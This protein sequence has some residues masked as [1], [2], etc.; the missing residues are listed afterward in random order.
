MAGSSGPQ[1]RLLFD[2][3]SRRGC[4]RLDPAAGVDGDVEPFSRDGECADGKWACRSEVD[5]ACGTSGSRPVV[6]V[7]RATAAAADRPCGRQ[8]AGEG[9]GT[10][11]SVRASPP[12]SS[13][14]QWSNAGT[15]AGIS[16]ASAT[17]PVLN[18]RPVDGCPSSATIK[19][20]K[21]S[22]PR[23][24]RPGHV[25]AVP[26]PVR[27]LG[28]GIDPQG[29]RPVRKRHPRSSTQPQVR[30]VGAP[31]S[32][33]RLQTH[34]QRIQSVQTKLT[35]RQDKM[36]VSAGHRPAQVGR[37]GLEPTADGL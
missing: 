12:Q 14:S 18:G 28:L 10:G 1:R 17:G 2:D 19:G 7:M 29:S 13:G 5:A 16:T 34:E 6:P 36:N 24:R 25:C 8:A 32:T 4:Y 30:G 15:A 37:V 26:A 27:P 33:A 11:V 9:A 23:H 22:T 20:D 3:Q 31:S 35:I 21:E